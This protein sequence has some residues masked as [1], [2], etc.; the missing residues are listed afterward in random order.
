MYPLIK[1]VHLI[2]VAMTFVLFT[3]RFAWMTMDSPMLQRRWVRVLPHVNDTLLLL[4]GLSLAVLSSQYPFA[5]DWLTAK[6]VALL[7]YILLGTVALKRGR[8]KRVRLLAGTAAFLVFVYMLQVAVH[9]SATL[10][11]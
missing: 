2:C 6:L 8:S 3:L 9:R 7:V 10:W 4:A 5:Q 1:H 11:F